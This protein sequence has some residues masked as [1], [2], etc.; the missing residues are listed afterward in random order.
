MDD[1]FANMRKNGYKYGWNVMMYEYMETIPGLWKAVKGRI[2]MHPT[3]SDA[4]HSQ[5]IS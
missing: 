1:P 2:L 5:L 3:Y 4:F